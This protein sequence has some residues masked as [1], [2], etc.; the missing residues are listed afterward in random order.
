[1]SKS[2]K[3]RVQR[4]LSYALPAIIFVI[5]AG[6]TV[7]V[8]FFMREA[9]WD[10][11]SAYL[12]PFPM[13]LF[14]P[15]ALN[16][17]EMLDV[18][19]RIDLRPRATVW[20]IFA[21]ALTASYVSS[22]LPESMLEATILTMMASLGIWL[23]MVQATRKSKFRG[24]MKQQIAKKTGLSEEHPDVVRLTN[25]D[26]LAKAIAAAALVTVQVWLLTS[27]SEFVKWLPMVFGTQQSFSTGAARTTAFVAGALTGHLY[28]RYCP[29]Q[30]EIRELSADLNEKSGKSN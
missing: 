14:F 23:A 7:A 18:W 9:D 5:G 4:T 13:T 19:G 8:L 15:L 26:D 3:Q 17:A 29:N 25:N 6:W 10:T 16:L 12:M 30:T 21:S 24:L 20:C 1:M 28:H 27:S 2:I 11:Q 22:F